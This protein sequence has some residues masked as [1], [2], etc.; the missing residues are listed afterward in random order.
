MGGARMRLLVLSLVLM[1]TILSSCFAAEADSRVDKW[2]HGRRLLFDN[3][4]VRPSKKG[5]IHTVG[6]V[7]DKGRGRGLVDNNE[8]YAKD[9]YPSSSNV[10]NHHYIP[11][12]DFNQYG[13]SDV[14]G[15]SG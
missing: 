11:R 14:G 12:G 10:N 4:D 8:G 13:G 1:M 6:H 9:G 15:G 7:D 2:R 5:P 3:A